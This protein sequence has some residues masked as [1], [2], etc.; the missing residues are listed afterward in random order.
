MHRF[1]NNNNLYL[2]I[3][4][5]WYLR[6]H[7]PPYVKLNSF[8]SIFDGPEVAIVDAEVAGFVAVAAKLQCFAG[9]AIRELQV[10]AECEQ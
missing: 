7:C 10:L 9:F 5:F 1:I 6:V 8:N 2:Q 3:I 4:I